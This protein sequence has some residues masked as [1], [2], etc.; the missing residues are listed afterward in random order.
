MLPVT[1]ATVR[2]FLH[3]LGATVW[4]GGQI[5]LVKLVPTLRGISADAPR[6]AARRFNTIAWAAFA[7]LVVTGIWNVLAIDIG[8]TT[9]T[10][11]VTLAVKLTVVALSGIGAAAHSL[12]TSKAGLAIWG[13]VGLLAAL[14]AVFVGVLLAGS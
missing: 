13:A 12:S 2:L 7:L 1:W 8:D 10:Y 11:Q 3:I 5:T 14:A 4:V 6:L 9:T